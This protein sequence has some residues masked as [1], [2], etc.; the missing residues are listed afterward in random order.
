MK[1]FITTQSWA[2]TKETKKGVE[3][4]ILIPE[5]SALVVIKEDS[6][7]V[8]FYHQGH[9]KTKLN[10]DVFNTIPKKE[11]KLEEDFIYDWVIKP[12]EYNDLLNSVDTLIKLYSN[13]PRVI[14]WIKKILQDVQNTHGSSAINGEKY[15]KYDPNNTD[16][17]NG[18]TAKPYSWEENRSGRTTVSPRLERISEFES[19]SNIEVLPLGI[20]KS[21]QCSYSSQIELLKKLLKELSGVDG[22]PESFKSDMRK[23]GLEISEGPHYD[24]MEFDYHIKLEDIDKNEHHSKEKGIE[25]CHLYPGDG[26]NAKNVTLGLCKSNR[27]QSGNSVFQM[28]IKGFNATRRSLGL[29]TLTEEEFRQKLLV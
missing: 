18:F 21:Q 10:M 27:A 29:K 16:W 15:S 28:A 8:I 25:F 1:T 11:I 14:K 5:G 19:T 20:D 17:T 22:I 24:Y 6:K 26:T 2:L 23:L 13:N 7:S 12:Q 4:G 9:G 3:F